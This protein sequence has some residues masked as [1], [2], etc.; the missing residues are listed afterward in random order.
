MIMM[1]ETRMIRTFEDLESRR[2][3][4]RE[5]MSGK[6]RIQ[7]GLGTCGRAAGAGKT[8]DVFAESVIQHGLEADVI[9]VGCMGECAFE[10]MVEIIGTDGTS[11]IYCKVTKAV[12]EDIVKHHLVN[13]KTL[14]KYL[15]SRWKK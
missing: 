2:Q 4:V 5:R 3:T 13:G 6:T 10:P 1:S 9:Q 7:V 14:D 12:A 15:L 8:F 11:T